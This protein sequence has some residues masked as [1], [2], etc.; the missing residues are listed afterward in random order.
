MSGIDIHLGVLDAF[1]ELDQAARAAAGDDSGFSV[2]EI[3]DF[4]A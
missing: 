3:F 2:A 1:V 4:F